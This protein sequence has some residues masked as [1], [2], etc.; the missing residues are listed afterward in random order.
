MSIQ[1]LRLRAAVGFLRYGISGADR[2]RHEA[3]IRSVATRLGYEVAAILYDA[4]DRGALVSQIMVLAWN[5]ESAAVII[6]SDRHLERGEV[7]DLLAVGDVIIIESAKRY[8]PAG[9]EVKVTDLWNPGPNGSSHDNWGTAVNADD[10]GQD[11]AERI[12]QL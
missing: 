11:A 4:C 7:D 8:E 12:N 5:C 9:R 6:P 1:A 3:E 2:E 10:D